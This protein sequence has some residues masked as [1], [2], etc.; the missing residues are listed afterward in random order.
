M[1]VVMETFRL[2]GVTVEDA[3][4]RRKWRQMVKMKSLFNYI[5]FVLLPSTGGH[6]NLSD[7]NTHSW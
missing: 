7:F 2:V 3:G 5:I 1:D 4:D 6:K